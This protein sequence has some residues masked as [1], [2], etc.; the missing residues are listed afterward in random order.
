[1]QIVLS[2]KDLKQENLPEG[3]LVKKI[4]YSSIDTYEHNQDVVA[5]SGSR[6]MAIK[7]ANMDFPNLKL[8]QLTSAGFDGVPNDVYAKKGIAV[9]NAAPKAK[10]AADLVLD[11]TNNENAI[12]AIIERLERG[13]IKL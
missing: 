9:A 4:S 11:V 2:D 1:M 3:V 5:I 10:E 8:F 7:A 13:E 6:A 12:A